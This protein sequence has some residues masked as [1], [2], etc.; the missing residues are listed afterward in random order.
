MPFITRNKKGE[1]KAIHA[2]PPPRSNAEWVA[3][4]QM[5]EVIGFLNSNQT[6]EQSYTFME[7]SDLELIR[8]LEDLIDLLCEK[9]IIAYTELPDTAQHK[10]STRKKV[11]ETMGGF[12]AI[13]NEEEK[14]VI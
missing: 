10:L 5:D 4:E 3:P 1:I 11:R 2:T 12:A 13:I 9:H 14:G 6:A 8:V 7:T